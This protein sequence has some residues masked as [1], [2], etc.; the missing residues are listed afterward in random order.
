MLPLPSLNSPRW[1]DNVEARDG[2]RKVLSDGGGGYCVL[3]LAGWSAG[4]PQRT[5]CEVQASPLVWIA[6]QWGGHGK[7]MAENKEG[8]TLLHLGTATGLESRGGCHREPG[9][10]GSGWRG[11][12][13]GHRG[14]LQVVS[15][16]LSFLLVPS[17]S[18]S[19][20]LQLSQPSSVMCL[21]ASEAR[22]PEQL[23]R[24][25]ICPSHPR[26]PHT[27]PQTTSR[28]SGW[29]LLLQRPGLDQTQAAAWRQAGDRVLSSWHVSPEP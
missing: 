16:A 13:P 11:A 2:P 21:G 15:P 4:T 10:E 7:S 1:G 6:G 18:S 22:S 23:L 19:H 14:S 12:A 28:P 27:H 3:S 25:Q 29:P 9:L 20:A 8:E 24:K 5:K 26:H 17:P